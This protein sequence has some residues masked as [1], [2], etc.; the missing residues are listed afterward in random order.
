MAILSDFE[1]Q[2]HREWRPNTETEEEKLCSRSLPLALP[3][4]LVTGGAALSPKLRYHLRKS[5]AV[6][7]LRTVR[8]ANTHSFSLDCLRI[9]PA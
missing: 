3:D 7:K 9:Q 6:S 5:Q 8:F 4:A 1:S 2:S